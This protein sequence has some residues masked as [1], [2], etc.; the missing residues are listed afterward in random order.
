MESSYELTKLSPSSFE[1]LVNLLAIKVL[2][3]GHTGFG[4]GS[5]GGRDGY[6]EGEAPYPSVSDRWRGRWY[7]QSKFHAPHLSKDPQKWLQEQIKKEISLFNDPETKRQ[8]PDNWIVATNIDPAGVPETGTFDAIRKIVYEENPQLEQHFSIW[9]GRKILDLLALHPEVAEYY[10]HFLSPGHIFTSLYQLLDDSKEEIETILRHLIVRQFTEQ[11]YTKLE[12]A[13]S[14]ADTRPGI[15][16]LFIDLPFQ[17]SDYETKGMVLDYLFHTSSRSHLIN[18]K[19][20]D[21]PLW[22]LWYRHP[23]RARVWFLKGGPGQGKSTV[24]QYFCQLQRAALILQD[25]CFPVIPVI[26]TL[27]E[28]I[29]KEAMLTGH[30]PIV[31]RIPISIELKE[32]AH[33]FGQKNETEPKGVLSFLAHKLSIGIETVIS[34]KTLKKALSS[35]SWFVTFDGL[36]EV[37][38]DVKEGIASEVNHFLND[39]VIE[40]NSDMLALCTS[41]PQGYS[42]QFSDIDG[43]EVDLI[44]LSKEQAL[45]CARPVLALGRSVEEAEKYFQILESAMSSGSVRE[46]MTSPLQAHIMAVVIR[47]GGKPP[48]RR[49]QLYSNFYMVIK[50]REANRDLP[51]KKLAKLLREDEKLL[52]T[53]H[54]R[55]GFIL[56]AR[57]ETSSGAQTRL[58]RIEFSTLITNAVTQMIEGDT[59]DTVKVLMDATTNRLV[60]VN[61]PD[62]GNHLRFDIRPLQEFFAAEF[63]YESISAD[64]LRKRIEIIAGD[65]HWREVMHFLL[66]A[67]VENNRLTELT[68]ALKVLEELN[69]GASDGSNRLLSRRIGRGSLIAGRIL[70]EGVLEQ[71]KRIR[72]QFRKCLEPLG[73]FVDL[74]TIQF[75]I[76]TRTSNS[77]SWFI[78][79]LFDLISEADRTENIGASILLMH[80]LEDGDSRILQIKKYLLSSPPEY[81]NMIFHSFHEEEF[82]LDDPKCNDWVIETAISLLLKSNWYFLGKDG[83][84]SIIT[85][86][87]KH[88]NIF[89]KIAKN[90]GLNQTQAHLLYSLLITTNSSRD[91]NLSDENYGLVV[92]MHYETDW[93]NSKNVIPNWWLGHEDELTIVTGILELGIK[94]YRFSFNKTYSNF[95]DILNYLNNMDINV[96]EVLPGHVRAF[97]PIDES[98]ILS[99]QIKELNSLTQKKFQTLFT[100]L[101]VNEKKIIRPL[102]GFRLEY[103]FD[104]S[105]WE[106]LVEEWPDIAFIIWPENFWNDVPRAKNDFTVKSLHSVESTKTLIDRLIDCPHLLKLS[107]GSWGELIKD[108]SFMELEIRNAIRKAAEIPMRIKIRNRNYY[109]FAI[110]LPLDQNLIP[111]LLTALLR[112][113]E[114]SIGRKNSI[115]IL[116]NIESNIS[117][118]CADI[119]EYKKILHESNVHPDVKIATAILLLLFP[120]MNIEKDVIVKIINDSFYQEIG[121]WFFTSIRI[122]MYFFGSENDELSRILLEKLLDKSRSNYSSRLELQKVLF[123]WRETSY[124]PIEK[125]EVQERWLQGSA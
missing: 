92:G 76:D 89:T 45:K 27:A 9:G 56:H 121:E 81:I 93:T 66:S 87:N 78:S 30:W 114:H 37:P 85:L 5:D 113:H 28:E 19:Q 35:R 31:P 12:Q 1:H 63:I 68:V 15:H 13:G 24:G 82:S 46:L 61:T 47:D 6:F 120:N 7:I 59:T 42:G 118:I 77:Y 32:Y 20:K 65:A 67:L 119:N 40:A 14:D 90:A 122:Y 22:R 98:I 117:N 99:D 25:D 10:A 33:W 100:Q 36:D 41:R 116:K 108:G 94:I 60:L 83:L 106:K 69:E 70:Q 110:T 44:A 105:K 26:K 55:L 54:N 18:F 97:L 48:E 72:Q 49:W 111:Y 102:T 16:R 80:M 58:N 57:A 84:N 2:G 112:S 123:K 71:D 4:P 104:P 38:H 79:F 34:V 107:P 124:A 64:E 109:S 86:L 39:I 51:D 8:W 52:K 74:R 53:V 50:R 125:A 17:S 62:D 23:S 96:L 115:E 29:K 101:K 21:S 95:K 75:L 91:E 73:G 3:S 103:K 11:Q 88:R 43:P